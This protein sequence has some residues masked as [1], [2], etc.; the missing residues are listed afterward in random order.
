MATN[1]A[2]PV[3]LFALR[4]SASKLQHLEVEVTT[5]EA[6]AP[7]SRNFADRKPRAM[8]EIF[9]GTVHASILCVF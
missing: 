8:Q 2:G 7:F 6:I 3:T 9:H 1:A 5:K 4:S